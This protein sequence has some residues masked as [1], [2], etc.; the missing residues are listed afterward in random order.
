MEPYTCFFEDCKSPIMI[1]SSYDGWIGHIREFHCARHWQCTAKVH[2]P[3]TFPVEESF[4]QHMVSA[5]PGTFT[6][7]QLDMLV[8]VKSKPTLELFDTCPLCG[9]IPDDCLPSTEG[10]DGHSKPDRLARHIGGELKSL[11]M[12][13][14]THA[15][16]DRQASS[17][18]GIS[19]KGSHLEDVSLTFTENI[20][21][22]I[23]VP[24]K[25][26]PTFG[27]N[28]LEIA[29]RISAPDAPDHDWSF[30]PRYPYKGHAEDTTVQTIL[31]RRRELKA[32]SID[33]GLGG[34]HAIFLRQEDVPFIMG[35]LLGAG[36]SSRVMRVE[37]TVTGIIY[38]CKIFKAS[39]GPMK[40][41]LPM[42]LA[43]V[44]VLKSLT[45]PHVVRING[46]YEVPPRTAA[47]VFSPVADTDLATFLE[48]TE[49]ADFSTQRRHILGKWI[50]C[51]AN[52]VTYIHSQGVR[53]KD[54]N[55]RNILCE[56]DRV[57]LAGFGC[58][59]TLDLLSDREYL[60]KDPWRY[61]RM[62]DA[63]EIRAQA[64]RGLSADIFSLGCVFS[65]MFTVFMG[66]SLMDFSAFRGYRDN[67]LL[68]DFHD[69][70]EEVINW[71]DW[72]CQGRQLIVTM[73][74]IVP[75]LAREG[76][77]RPSAPDV[78]SKI[79]L[80]LRNEG[81]PGVRM[82]AEC[83]TPTTHKLFSGQTGGFDQPKDQDAMAV[84]RAVE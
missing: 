72:H 22:N 14:T 71:F 15:L 36:L 52:A 43:E 30:V 4:R 34:A 58:G 80:Q 56:G 5:H 26:F 81:F 9:G 60:S 12:F 42:L 24:S 25:G 68:Q 45:H 23:P 74:V 55:P 28:H 66:L 77:D 59:K 65:E 21:E 6:I 62:Y 39:A 44:V 11:A 7:S 8:D 46:T 41:F 40:I 78:V 20:G 69:T 67:G 57:L 16:D 31:Q 17:S 47:M 51:L 64:S 19:A 54:I 82:C 79:I 73:K 83:E 13:L 3:M 70:I 49:T 10:Q 37:S 75:M 35:D 50:L 61:A 63:P 76:S 84:M 27:A 2:P 33:C 38:A 32:Q 29:S 1:F 18:S 48:E 53:H